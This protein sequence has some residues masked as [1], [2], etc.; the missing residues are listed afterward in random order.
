M[1][2]RFVLILALG[3]CC[4]GM[5][6]KK[7]PVSVRFYTQTSSNDSDSFATAV[8]LLNGQQTTVDDIA[9]ISEHDIVAIFPFAAQD[10][11]GG[12]SFQLDDHGTI[13]LDSLSS[14]KRGTLLIATIDGRQLADL[15]IDKR[16]TD[17]VVTIPAG[18]NTD[19]MKE[20]LKKYPVIGGKKKLKRNKDGYSS[21]F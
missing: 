2:A 5:G 14:A 10:G 19:E 13:G 20:L 15:L 8:T 11:S 12:C 17:G 16:I 4:L 3:V 21:G 9:A 7:L 6:E 18:I 1:R